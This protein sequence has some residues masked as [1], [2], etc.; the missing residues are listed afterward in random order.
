MVAGHKC[1]TT[2]LS[3]FVNILFK[4]LLSNINVNVINVNVML[5][6]QNLYK[7]WFWLSQKM[8][9]KLNKKLMTCVLWCN[10]F[11]HQFTTLGLEA[12]EYWLNKYSEL[13]HSLD[14]TNLFFSEL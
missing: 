2:R 10:K 6:T 9:E 5:L 14:L 11:I 12:I 1:P 8:Q 4:P 3:N 7:R 13:N